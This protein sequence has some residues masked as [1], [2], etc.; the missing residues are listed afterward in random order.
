[1]RGNLAPR[2]WS[3]AGPSPRDE[4][5]GKRSL[6]F[7][8]SDLCRE[9]LI[10]GCVSSPPTPMPPPKV[11][12]R[13]T[14]Y[15]A[16][17]DAK[18]VVY[19]VFP[20]SKRTIYH[21]RGGESQSFP[22]I[23]LE[24]FE[25]LPPGLYL[26]KSGYGFGRKGV[27]LLASIKQHLARGKP[28][29]LV[30]IKTGSKSIRS[31]ARTVVTLPYDD[32]R[33]LLV[34]FSRINENNNNELRETAASFLS[35]K[36]PTKVKAGATKYDEYQAGEIASIL[37]RKNV[38]QKLNE[39]DLRGLSEF[40][41][42]VF[43]APLKGRKNA[44]KSQRAALIA[45]TKGATDRI[46]LDEVIREFEA[47]LKKRASEQDW[48]NF[49]R[50]KVFRFLANYVAAIEKQ[51]V[52]IDVSYPD[53]VMVDVYGFIDVFEIKRHDTSLMAFDASHDN[54]YWK[55]EVAQAISQIE[56]Y[57]DAVIRNADEYCRAVKRKK[58][59]DIKVVRPRGYIV[60]GS[61]QQFGSEKEVEDFR[62]L[63]ASLKNI[64][65]ILYDELLERLKNLR[66]KL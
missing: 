20:K 51:N 41:P 15:Y 18:V 5:V 10:L 46:F 3:G 48:Q 58:S 9:S 37:R 22:T 65:F 57:I 55:P 64:S 47:M 32:V 28:V 62:K 43:A 16:S 6:G 34:R 29:D 45:N 36:F 61:S 52:S 30:I 63:G 38:A 66:S 50:D 11:R 21:N 42:K 40:F 53:F 24:G 17:K 49:L 2:N 27:F 35:S 33:N 56:N 44:I 23:V 54:Y 26:K 59:V 13:A 60:A 4:S 19:E 8:E 39:E 1:M 14:T 12:E 7:G 25:G 31:G